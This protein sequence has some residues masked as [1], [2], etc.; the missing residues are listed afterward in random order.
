VARSKPPARPASILSRHDFPVVFTVISGLKSPK[1]DHTGSR[2]VPSGFQPF[3]RASCNICSQTSEPQQKYDESPSM[4]PT[5]A[6]RR[7]ELVGLDV[8]DC[9][10]GKD[11][12]TVALRR[13][14]TDQNGAG[15]EDRHP[16]RRESRDVPGTRAANLVRAGW[17]YHGGSAVFARSHGMGM[18]SRAGYRQLTCSRCEGAR[19]TCGP[20]PGQYAGH[21]LRAGHATSAAIAGASDHEPDWASVG[22]YIRDGSLFR[23]NG[24]GKLGL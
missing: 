24:A 13:S 1:S 23:E 7:S 3:L 17:S 18:L 11:G 19:T 16:L 21:S 9:C 22:R 20:R 14:K 6:F 5:T 12:S 8:E 15:P 2:L 4:P 10:F